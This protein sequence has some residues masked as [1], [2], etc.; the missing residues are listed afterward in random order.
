MEAVWSD[1]DPCLPRDTWRL[2]E[3]VCKARVLTIMS[4]AGKASECVVCVP[5]RTSARSMIA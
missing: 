1:M 3:I 2:G 5:E 4:C